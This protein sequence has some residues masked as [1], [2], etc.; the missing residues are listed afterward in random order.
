MTE[1]EVRAIIMTMKSK[2]YETDPIPTHIFK[3]LLSSILPTVTEIVNLSLSEGE[4]YNKWK[5]TVVRPLLKK[6]GLELI[7]SNYRPIINL[8]FMFKIIEK[9]MLHQFNIYCGTY[10]LLPNYQSAYHEN[11]SCETCFLQLSNDILWVFEHQSITSLTVKDLSS[12]FDTIEHSILTSVLSNKF[13]IN[14]TALKWL[15]IYLWPR[16]FK[17]AVNQKVFWGKTTYLWCTPR[18]LFRC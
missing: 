7:K 8:T 17:V 5:V 1:L 16:S 4:F 2:S 9:C 3:L 6:V 13:G 14:D 18:F 12:A 15:N 11:Y 10:D